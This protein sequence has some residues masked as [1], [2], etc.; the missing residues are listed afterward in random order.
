VL[1][2]SLSLSLEED[3]SKFLFINGTLI[4]LSSSN[5]KCLYLCLLNA[6]EILNICFPNFEF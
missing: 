1:D 2:S 4:L 5:L 3:F 6:I